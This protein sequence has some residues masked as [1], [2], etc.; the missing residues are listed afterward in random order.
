MS[1]SLFQSVVVVSLQLFSHTCLFRL[2]FHLLPGTAGVELLTTCMNNYF[3]RV[4]SMILSYNG[5]VIKFAGDSMIVAFWP[6]EEEAVGLDTHA[7]SQ[8]LH[9]Q[10]TSREKHRTAGTASKLSLQFICTA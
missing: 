1:S 6:S 2:L 5:D 4:I 9:S 7:S 3:T 8:P 10:N